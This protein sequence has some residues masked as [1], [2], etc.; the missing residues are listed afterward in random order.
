MNDNHTH[1][2]ERG[3]FYNETVACECGDTRK[4]TSDEITY[5]RELI[6]EGERK[7]MQDLELHVRELRDASDAIANA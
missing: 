7:H 2:F 1:E 5:E 4:M 3:D 6:A